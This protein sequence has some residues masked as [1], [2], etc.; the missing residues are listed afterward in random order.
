MRLLDRV[1]RFLDDVLLPEELREALDDA[2][3][4]AEAGALDDAERAYELVL[5]ARPQAA[6]ARFGLA[7]VRERAGRPAEALE[8][9]RPLRE[10]DPDDAAV[11]ALVARVALALGRLDEAADAARDAARALAGEGGAALAGACALRARVERARGRPDRARRE[12][13]KAVAAAPADLALRLELLE[14]LAEAQREAEARAVAAS[15][16]AHA[17]RADASDAARVGAALVRAGASDAAEPWLARAAEA[18]HRDAALALV[19]GWLARAA[20]APEAASET[21]SRA[22][23]AARRAVAA[24]GGAEALVALGDVLVARGDAAGGVDAWLA[25]VSARRR[26]PDADAA[27]AARACLHAPARDVAR[28]ERAASL[29]A[30]LSGASDTAGGSP[31]G[32]AQRAGAVARALAALARGRPDDAAATLAD[33]LGEADALLPD[34]TSEVAATAVSGGAA[35]AA[36]SGLAAEAASEVAAT[37]VSGGAAPA[38]ESGLAAEAAGDSA[39]DP[40]GP[41]DRAVRGRARL[42][43][44]EVLAAREQWSSALRAL[45]ALDRAALVSAADVARASELARALP[46]LWLRRDGG[47]LDVAA[48]LDVALEVLG[49]RPEPHGDARAALAREREGLDEPLLVAVLGEF[50]A[51]KS[52]LVN[53]IVG[54]PIAPTGVLPTTATLN[55]L[56]HGPVERVRVVTRDGTAHEGGVD[57]LGALLAAAERRGG[58]ESVDRVEIAVPSPA[59]ARVWLLD[60]PGVNALDPAHERLAR[61]AAARADVVLW[62]FSAA[63]AGKASEA[64]WLRP[65]LVEGR[66][67]VAVVNKADRLTAAERDAVRGALAQALPGLGAAA[68]SSPLGAYEEDARDRAA[69]SL[70]PAGGGLLGGAPLFVSARDGLDARLRGDAEAVAQSGLGAVL[71][72]FEGTLGAR[73]EELKRRAVASRLRATLDEALRAE[74]AHA[75]RLAASAAALAARRAALAPLRSRL[76]ADADAALAALALALGRAAEEAAAEVLAFWRPR[77]GRVARRGIDREDRAFLAEVLGDRVERAVR[78]AGDGVAE[79]WSAALADA[80]A[81]AGPA[82]R[83]D[84]RGGAAA[85]PHGAPTAAGTPPGPPVDPSLLAAMARAEATACFARLAGEQ[86]GLLAGGALDRFFSEVLPRAE[87]TLDALRPALAA[88]TV[89]P[90][91]SAR[92]ALR[93]AAA[94][95]VALLGARLARAERTALDASRRHRDDVLE[96]LEALRAVLDDAHAS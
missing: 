2:D 46:R 43:W 8:A 93:T 67:L 7:A 63:Q 76:E 77:R 91:A 45:A 34:A 82:V 42:A 83:L 24:G 31:A 15:L 29:T 68:G 33:V 13:R 30:S 20:A 53:A 89:D 74:A 28:L 26:G 90:G 64:A 56:R 85:P 78:A 32:P 95:L 66:P 55:V 12:L 21:L 39:P 50:N 72:V 40:R 36:E 44:A 1:G 18:G 96:P 25:A 62:V 75:E 48:A 19:R 84:P 41:D 47:A 4:R 37:A 58:A 51:G 69:L 73:A 38:A 94:R 27:L 80:S 70:R 57:A 11:A 9:A 22:E 16:D 92:P 23:D 86:R 88:A 52:T 6:R 3:A 61:R 59:L 65:L 54:A 14:T 49:R 17:E 35:P 10:A 87:P 60:T 5:A 79:R 81:S 71:A